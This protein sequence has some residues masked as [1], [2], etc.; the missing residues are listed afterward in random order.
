MLRLAGQGA[1]GLRGGKPGDLL[2]TV[3]V[4]GDRDFRR[5]GNDLITAVTIPL[6]TA[7][8]GGKV[9]VP[10]VKGTASLRIPAGTQPGAIL[11]MAGL[12]VKP[13]KGEAG[14]QLVEITVE[15]PKKL[16]AK[17]KKLIEEFGEE[18]G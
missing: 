2:I 3:N 7:L 18:G 6:T 14:N 5:K 15:I 13:A 11:R 10:T 17:Q 12:G 16:T 8:L 9:C 4:T 1:P